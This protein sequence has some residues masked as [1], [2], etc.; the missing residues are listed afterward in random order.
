[1]SLHHRISSFFERSCFRFSF[2]SPVTEISL[3]LPQGFRKHQVV[4]PLTEPGHTDLT[5]NVD[6]AYLAEA[7]SE[8]G[9]SS[10]SLSSHR[11]TEI[12]PRTQCG[13]AYEIRSETQLTLDSITTTTTNVPS[14]F[15]S[16]N[17][18]PHLP[19]PLPHLPRAPTSPRGPLAVRPDSR[20][21]QRDRE[22]RE[23]VGGPDGDG[24]A[25]QDY[26]GRAEGDREE[27]RRGRVPFQPRLVDI[28]KGFPTR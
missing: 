7:M 25:V 4:D 6:F 1:M 21:S 11:R 24:R 26:G 9:T 10:L 17:A 2:C 27:A 22:R 23:A 15:R 20:T 3:S 8:S 14:L 13:V 5:A 16:R 19:I 18:G 28:L 12:R